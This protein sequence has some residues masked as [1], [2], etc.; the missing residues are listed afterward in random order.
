MQVP[1]ATVGRGKAGNK[2]DMSQRAATASASKRRRTK[3]LDGVAPG[4]QAEEDDD[5]GPGV[6]QQLKE[7][8]LCALVREGMSS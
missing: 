2:T 8:C 3:K 5:E 6:A 7:V 4:D 1:G